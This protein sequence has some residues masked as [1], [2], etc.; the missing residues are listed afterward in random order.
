MQALL[1]ELETDLL[2]VALKGAE[3]ELIDKFLNNMS[4]RASQMLAEDMESQGPVRVSEVEAAQ[5]EILSLARRLAEEGQV[6]LG[7]SGDDFV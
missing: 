6:M 2:L 4:K 7:G 3:Q 5:R 1:R